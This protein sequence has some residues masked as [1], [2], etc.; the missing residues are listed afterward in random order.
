MA[1]YLII[2][3]VLVTDDEY[4][5]VLDESTVELKVTC[6]PDKLAEKISAKKQAYKNWREN[7]L[8][9]R[10]GTPSTVTVTVQQVLPL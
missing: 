9:S 8:L 6:E 2:L 4:D 7:K 3:K 1:K 5:W 10:M